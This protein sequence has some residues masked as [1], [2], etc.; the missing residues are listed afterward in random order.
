MTKNTYGTGCFLICNTGEKIIRSKNGLI[1]TIAWEINKKVSYAIEGSVFM[2]GAL[3]QWLRDEMNL[4]N[5]ASE[6]EKLALSVK[7]SNGVFVVPAFVGLGAPHWEPKVRGSILGLT[8]NTNKNHII[9]A[10]VESIAFQSSEVVHAISQDLGSSIKELRVDG[11]ASLNNFL[12][13]FQSNLL[14]ALVNRPLNIETTAL[15]A[16]FLAGL[17]CGIWKDIDEIKKLR[18]NFTVF[19]PS[20]SSENS[21]KLMKKWLRAIDTSKTWKTES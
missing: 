21:K 11:G 10:A 8:R 13:Q 20:I 1:S 12:C 3:I 16:A 18:K 4:I 2:G 14:G 9:R 17:G 19:K 6:S 7:D 5:D 15:G